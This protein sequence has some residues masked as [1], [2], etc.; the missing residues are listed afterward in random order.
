MNILIIKSIILIIA[1]I[2]NWFFAFL[3]WRSKKKEITIIFL[4]LCA[5]FSG[6]Y[7]LICAITNFTW[8]GN[9]SYSTKLFWNRTTWIGFLALPL[10]FSF[11]LYFVNKNKHF[12]TKI[13][14]WYIGAIVIIIL[15]IFTPLVIEKIYPES[16]FIKIEIGPVE[17]IGR[18]FLVSIVVL[19]IIYLVSYYRK[20]RGYK[21]LQVKYFILGFFVY[22]LFGIVFTGILPFIQKQASYFDFPAIGSIFWIGLSSYAILKYK[23]M[24]IRFV[25]GR[26]TVYIFTSLSCIT[27]A[28]LPSFLSRQIRGYSFSE[29]ITLLSVLI[30]VVFTFNPFFKLFEKVAGRYF[31]Y[32][33]F[34][35][36][37]S[38]VN[39]SE[40]LNKT[41]ELEEQINLIC[42][43]LKNAIKIEGISFIA[44]NPKKKELEIK[45]Y[46][47]L[48]KED[49]SFLISRKN[50]FFIEILKDNHQPILVNEISELEQKKNKITATHSS[51]FIEKN[52]KL[53]KIEKRLENGGI[54]L[55][56]PLIIGDE[57]I[58][59]LVLGVKESGDGFTEQ[60]LKLFPSLISQAAIALNNAISYEEIK[61][62]KQ[63]LERFYN[64]TIGR[65]LKMIEL[66][67]ENKKLKEIIGQKKHKVEK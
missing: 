52:L 18:I 28:S 17:P 40:K 50:A 11:V 24:D 43:T 55:L 53:E 22:A 54:D 66:K 65:E 7:A 34:S 61:I 13:L 62:R 32:T 58:G 35:L 37:E 39:L 31:Y 2:I 15:T 20:T 47:G 16:S 59:L 63:E 48:K 29:D 10:Y 64:V 1:G 57:L 12:F 41:I 5:I 14:P 51:M 26:A 21:R 9:F 19:S 27:L 46:E 30:I 8:Q 3:L 6:L 60:E 36:K 23:L 33:Y 4:Q 56:L 25:L 44:K 38:L 45:S 67:Q 49:I 42:N